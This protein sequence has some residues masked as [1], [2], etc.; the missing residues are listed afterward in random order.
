MVTAMVMAMVTRT[1][2]ESESEYCILR[3]GVSKKGVEKS[4]DQ[5]GLGDWSTNVEYDTHHKL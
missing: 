3:G 4:S 2:A 5:N 1:P